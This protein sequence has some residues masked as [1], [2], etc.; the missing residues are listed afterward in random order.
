MGWPDIL[1]TTLSYCRRRLADGADPETVLRCLKEMTEVEAELRRFESGATGNE[2]L[3]RQIGWSEA[4]RIGHPIL[5]VQHIDLVRQINQ[6]CAALDAKEDMTVKR[7]SL[8][9]LVHSTKNHFAD[10]IGFLHEAAANSP[11]GIRRALALDEAAINTHVA[12]HGRAFADLQAL[13]G[14][15]EGALADELPRHVEELIGWFVIEAC[16]YDDRL[17]TVLGPM[18]A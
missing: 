2:P 7:V 12:A 4:F 16:Q 17:N 5:D 1:R 15:I 18:L 8:Q 6:I 9:T 11:P 13:V 10:E 14:R 3:R